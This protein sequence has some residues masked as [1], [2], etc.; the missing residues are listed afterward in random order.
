MGQQQSVFDNNQ[1][2]KYAQCTYFKQKDILRLYKIFSKL[3]PDRINPRFVDTRTRLSFAQMQSLPE[4]REN[5]FKVRLCKVF[6]TN[7]QGINFEDFLDMFSVL[8]S[9]APWELKAAYAF[10]V[11]DYNGDAGIC[12]DDIKQIVTSLVG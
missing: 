4:L 3:D 10:R 9:H 2:E 11:F 1:F 7:G 5:P 8:S 12:E 6:S